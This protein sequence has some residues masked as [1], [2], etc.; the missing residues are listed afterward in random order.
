MD[1]KKYLTTMIMLLI[2]YGVYGAAKSYMNDNDEFKNY[3]TVRHYLV[4]DSSLAKSKLPILW[5][6]MD[7]EQN[8]RWWQNFYS[9]NSKDLN[10]P[11][12]Y[13]TIKSIIDQC[14]SHFNVCMIDDETL[15]N[16]I[17]GWNTEI[18]KLSDPIKGKLRDLAQAYILKYYGGMFVPAS[19]LCTKNLANMYYDNVLD[20]KMFVGELNNENIT[21]DKLDVF[22]SKKFMGAHKNAKIIDKYIH[23]IQSLISV[24]YTCES[25]FKGGPDAW[26][27]EQSKLDNVTVINAKY[28]GVKDVANKNVTLD[29]LIGNSFVDFCPAS[30]GIYFPQEQLLNRT[31]YQWFATLS[32]KQALESDTVMGKL[33][34]SNYVC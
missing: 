24:D 32:A 20:G 26:L 33:L 34:V 9:R 22:V 1:Y 12:L 5:I 28:L 29:N 14:G 18:D 21:S 2:A 27:Y 6:Y 13:L 23:Y 3:N 11:Y 25:I 31:A 4:N 17:P 19:F 8:S 15:V 10:Q 7:Y 30:L 16:I